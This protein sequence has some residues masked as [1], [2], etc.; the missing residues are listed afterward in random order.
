MKKNFGVFILL[1]ITLTLRA[2][3]GLDKKHTY[4]YIEV[5]GRYGK[6]M[7]H[8]RIME[9]IYSN[10]FQAMEF[11]LGWQASGMDN[12]SERFNYPKYGVAFYTSLFHTKEIGNPNAIFGFVDFPIWRRQKIDK[13]DISL[14]V[15]VSFGFNHFD[16]ISNPYNI[17]IGSYAN[18]YFDLGLRYNIMLGDR[19]SLKP[20]LNFSHFSNGSTIQP[21]LGLNMVDASLSIQYRFYNTKRQEENVE[22][23]EFIHKDIDSP[24]LKKNN[25][26]IGASGGIRQNSKVADAFYKVALITT[27]YTRTVN[28]VYKIGIGLDF[29][30]DESIPSQVLGLDGIVVPKS[31]ANTVG[32][33][34]YNSARLWRIELGINLGYHVYKSNELLLTAYTRPSIKMYFTDNIYA[35]I[36]LK[37]NNYNLVAEYIEWGIGINVF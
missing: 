3:V 6:I 7:P 37:T 20:G 10:P 23:L 24:I 25:W 30:H 16:A 32:V 4:K 26:Y 21:N 22:T 13:L 17:A 35:M 5:V 18:L 12:W 28:H 14:G 1:F 31:A 29:M 2:Q 19:F 8:R 9:H 27:G 36:S 15:G 33:S 11:R 34:I